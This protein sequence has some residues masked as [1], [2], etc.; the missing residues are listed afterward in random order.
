MMA[1]LKSICNFQNEPDWALNELATSIGIT[2]NR[3]S[4]PDESNKRF[5]TF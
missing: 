4:V 2:L 5:T 1:T 3:K